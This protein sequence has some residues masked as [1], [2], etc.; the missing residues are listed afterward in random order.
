MSEESF[1]IVDKQCKYVCDVGNR[2]LQIEAHLDDSFCPLRLTLSFSPPKFIA[3]IKDAFLTLLGYNT[4]FHVN[5]SDSVYQK[6]RML[7]GN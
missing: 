5:V 3:R 4:V 7:N 6:L 2:K 1:D